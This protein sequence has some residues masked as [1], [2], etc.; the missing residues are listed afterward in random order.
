MNCFFAASIISSLKFLSFGR[1]LTSQSIKMPHSSSLKVITFDASPSH[2]RIISLSLSLC[3]SLSLSLS[4]CLSLSVSLSLC[5]PL[6]LLWIYKGRDSVNAFSRM[7]S[8]IKYS[9]IAFANRTRNI[10]CW[11]H[12]WVIIV[13]NLSAS[14][15]VELVGTFTS[16]AAHRCL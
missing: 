7:L 12:A 16:I 14:I 15:S 5:L 8:K 6:F 3:L 4:L 1:V 13:P 9:K 10:L 11:I 2:F